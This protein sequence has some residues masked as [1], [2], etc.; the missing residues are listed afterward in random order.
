LKVETSS[1]FGESAASGHPVDTIEIL[2]PP[3]MP[4]DQ[5]LIR[6]ADRAWAGSW[7]PGAP[8]TF[9][10]ETYIVRIRDS[11]TGELK[12]TVTINLPEPIPLSWTYSS[13][14]GTQANVTVHDNGSI[15]SS[16]P[17]GS[18]LDYASQMLTGNFTL[19]FEVDDRRFY[20][21]AI[22]AYP[23]VA[24]PGL[25]FTVNT[26]TN[27]F[28]SSGH[29]FTEDRAIEFQIDTGGTLPSPL[30]VGVRYY[31]VNVIGDDFQIAVTPGGSPIDIT[32]SGSGPTGVRFAPTGVLRSNQI[33]NRGSGIHRRGI[34]D[35]V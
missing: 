14:S 19:E 8:G 32:S 34:R 15:E 2:A 23:F 22:R 10:P 4:V 21:L 3:A 25:S 20:L 13:G 26:T 28:S 35:Y 31:V 6:I 16:P 30:G 5:T 29:P 24:V 11:T 33:R 1:L 18:G 27:V 12:R 9:E 7:E 17:L